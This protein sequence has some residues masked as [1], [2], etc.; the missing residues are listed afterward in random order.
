MSKTAIP[1]QPLTFTDLARIAEDNRQYLC[2]IA[3]PFVTPHCGAQD[4]LHTAVVRA[5]ANLQALRRTEAALPWL[6]GFVENVGAETVRTHARRQA[7]LTANCGAPR[8][9]EQDL[10]WMNAKNVPELWQAV[11]SLSSRAR[12]VLISRVVDEMT[13]K[14]TAAALGIAEGTV[15]SSLHRTLQLLRQ[16]LGGDEHSS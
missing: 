12:D 4:I 9:E 2:G 14:E 11:G 8:A 7:F 15:K 3:A 6:A 5:A 1:G 10:S 16:Q 13:V